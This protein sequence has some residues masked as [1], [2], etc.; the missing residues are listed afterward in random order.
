[1]KLYSAVADQ[2]PLMAYSSPVPTT[3]PNWFAETFTSPGKKVELVKKAVSAFRSRLECSHAPPPFTYRS[4]RPQGTPSRPVRV[5]SAPISRR[6]FTP[7]ICEKQ[8]LSPRILAKLASASTPNTIP[9]IPPG[10]KF[11]PIWPPESGPAT[12]G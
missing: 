10:W 9:P 12:C 8:V 6:Q 3:Q 7:P 1:M 4:D 11:Q 2:R 5:A